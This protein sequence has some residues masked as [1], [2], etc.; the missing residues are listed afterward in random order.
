[1]AL[2]VFP[3]GQQRSGK[4]GGSVYSH[5]RSGPYVRNRSI[6]VNPNTSRQVE[7]RN[8]VRSL[9]I[10]WNNDL[11][12]AQRSAWDVYAA[13]VSWT[14]RVGQTI[15]LTGM[16][17]FTRSNTPLLVSQYDRVD[18]APTLFNIAVAES[19]LSGSGSAAAQTIDV[20]FLAGPSWISE[21]DARQFVYMGL[22]QN[23][24][25]TFFGGP[26]RLLGVIEGDSTTPP[27]SPENFAAP[28]TFGEGQR[29]WLRS[30]ISRADGRLSEFAQ[31][32][33]LGAA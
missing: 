16:N 23:E 30:R 11:T 24:S 6:P 25:R 32:N 19:Y 29:I 28:F 4:A 10:G 14:N 20:G 27:T 2:I 33:F 9:A 31:C 13:N 5:N 8:A 22:P 26:Y 21:D 18:A 17:H 15:H 1:M 3:E 12:N 7:V